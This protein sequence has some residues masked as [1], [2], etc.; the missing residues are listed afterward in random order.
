MKPKQKKPEIVYRIIER[1][2]GEAQGSY[3]RACCDEYDFSSAENA[4]SANCHGMFED[5]SKYAIAKYRVTY[6]LLDEDAG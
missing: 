3:S 2:T 1:S 4:R 5:K 6:E